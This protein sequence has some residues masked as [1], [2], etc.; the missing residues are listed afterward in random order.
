MFTVEVK[1]QQQSYDLD[2][3]DSGGQCR[4]II[5]LL[6]SEGLDWKLFI[7]GLYYIELLGG[8]GLLLLLIS[9]Q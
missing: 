9:G 5:V 4:T 2:A 1:Q 6:S 3:L 7:C 8:Y